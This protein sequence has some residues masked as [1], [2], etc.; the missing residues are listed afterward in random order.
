MLISGETARYELTH[1]NQYRLL[2]TSILL[3]AL[4]E[5][6]HGRARTHANVSIIFE[7]D[8]GSY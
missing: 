6:K 1:L 4:K 2:K 8:F 3:L 5:L 7:I